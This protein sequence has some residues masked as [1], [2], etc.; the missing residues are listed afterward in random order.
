M[1]E[2]GVETNQVTPAGLVMSRDLQHAV[3][4]PTHC[5]AFFLLLFA[6]CSLLNTIQH[7]ALV[8]LKKYAW[9]YIAPGYPSDVRQ[10]YFKKR[11]PCRNLP[12]LRSIH[13]RCFTMPQVVWLSGLSIISAESRSLCSTSFMSV[14]STIVDQGRVCC[15]RFFTP[16]AQNLDGHRQQIQRRRSTACRIGIGDCSASS[17]TKLCEECSMIPLLYAKLRASIATV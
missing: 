9:H 7:H 2:Q 16:F 6:L 11:N 4:P 1:S 12:K 8:P 5:Q 17:T 3:N 10:R 15:Q 14:K 13:T